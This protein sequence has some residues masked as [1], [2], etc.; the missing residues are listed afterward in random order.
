MA[1]AALP[2]L[3]SA[4]TGVTLATGDTALK[5]LFDAA[6]SQAK[7]N[8][9]TFGS[10]KVMVE[11]GGYTN[12][13]IETQPMAGEMYAKRDLTIAKNNQ[14]VFIQTRRADGR[15][16]GMVVWN[17]S[18]L[19]PDYEMLQGYCFPQPAFEVYYLI[20][21]DTVYLDALYGALAGHDAYLWKARDS[22][23][24]GILESWCIWDTG[25]DGSV[26]YAP[27]MVN[28]WNSETAP[29]ADKYPLPIQS[30]S[31]MSYSY[32]GRNT[33]AQI[34]KVLNN[35]QE[36]AWRAKVDSV[37]SRFIANLWDPSR[38]AAFDRDRNNQV[39]NMLLHHN[40]RCMYWGVFTQSMADDFI[41]YHLLNPY[42]FWT[43]IPLPSIAVTDTNFKNNEPNDWSG[44]PMA[45]TFQRAIRALENYGHYAEVSLLGLIYT[46]WYEKD[47]TFVQQ[48]D[49]FTGNKSMANV[50]YGPSI[51]S[52]LEYISRLYGIHIQK[53]TVNWCGMS[54]PGQ[55]LTYTQQWNTSQFTISNTNGRFTG[56][57]NNNKVFDC[58]DGERVVTDLQGHVLK[59]IGIDTVMHAV[60]LIT[61]GK[62]F[63]A[64][65]K[66][67]EVYQ[68]DT[69]AGSLVLS[70]SAPFD[71]PARDSDIAHY[72]AVNARTS[73]DQ[74][75]GNCVWNKA[76]LTDGIT[77]GYGTCGYSSGTNS[78]ASANEWVEIDL[79]ADTVFSRV[80]IFPRVDRLTP[81]GITANFPVDFTIQVKPNA[82][83]YAVAYSAT[84]YTNPMVGKAQIFDIGSQK[85]RYVKVNA[86]TLGIPVTGE[87]GLYRLQLAEVEV[88]NNSTAVLHPE[89]KAAPLCHQRKT[90][91][92]YGSRFAIP[93]EFEG[94]AVQITVFD[95]SG[96]CLRTQTTDKR[97]V[98]V[99]KEYGFSKGVYIVQC[100]E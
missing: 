70:S 83:T 54:R 20:G 100:T 59:V 90:I 88:F 45:L 27:S 21:K 9:N 71:Y 57:V 67:N 69:S 40:L 65:I 63:S 39:I 31:V 47:H 28:S 89:T 64:N 50:A 77:K 97:S 36:T 48:C 60:S 82:G 16:P 51:L 73:V 37:R 80:G 42:E 24:N 53:D 76:Y 84:G 94:N 15:L 81:T 95:L 79:G 25:D 14:L 52:V 49:P 34:S 11:G 13:W 10:M 32:S 30:M 12:V 23:N 98:D 75:T 6:E 58:T 56:T 87:A 8:I 29:G 19:A 18:S 35:G 46:R 7:S 3:L 99:Q 26:L 38:H 17:G 96:K 78:S 33:L 41:H 44:M 2:A 61:S 93:K 62:T 85:A 66:P 86:T 1:A 72:K 68:C 43:P 5:S 22:D 4:Q 74:T 91:K 92:V 55:S